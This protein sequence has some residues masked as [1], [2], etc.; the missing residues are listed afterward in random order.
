MSLFSHLQA[1][2][3]Q[4][5][6]ALAQAQGMAAGGSGTFTYNGATYIGVFGQ[7]T[8]IDQP[9]SFGGYK[10]V[11]TLTL[12]A[13]RSQFTAAPVAKQRLTR[14]TPELTEF[15]IDAMDPHDP[16]HYVM[17]LVKVG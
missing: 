7:T 5:Q 8:I 17:R 11:A 15:L 3:T 12:T 13:T 1:T 10:R 6:S 14:T 2:F 16:H 4:A 9:Q